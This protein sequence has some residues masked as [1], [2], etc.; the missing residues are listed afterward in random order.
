VQLHQGRALL[1]QHQQAGGFPVQP[2][3]QFQVFPVRVRLAQLFDHAKGHAA[4]AMHGHAGRLVDHQQ[5]IVFVYHRKAARRH[6]I[7][8][9]LGQADGRNADLVASLDAIG[10]VDPAL[11]HPDFARAQMR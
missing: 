10:R 9:A 8:R 7:D 6:I 11:V 3:Y 2:V 4:A 1:G 5:G